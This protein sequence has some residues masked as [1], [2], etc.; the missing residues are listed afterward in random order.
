MLILGNIATAQIDINSPDCFNDKTCT[1]ECLKDKYCNDRFMTESRIEAGKLLYDSAIQKIQNNQ[2]LEGFNSLKTLADSDLNYW[3][4]TLAQYQI[5]NMYKSAQGV[6]KDI[7]L[8]I[9]YFELSIANGKNDP[10]FVNSP[11]LR[12]AYF[13]LSLLYAMDSK[14]K[15][16][17]LS[18]KNLFFAARKNCI[19]AQN[20]L[21]ND[22]LNGN[23]IKKNKKLSLALR[24]YE[25]N[26]ENNAE[27]WQFIERTYSIDAKKNLEIYAHDDIDKIIKSISKTEIEE[28]KKLSMNEDEL[29][30]LI[31]KTIVK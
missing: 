17:R 31:E 5:G 20:N 30:K 26:N 13:Q 24:F 10:I 15:N 29:F 25:I 8:S 21:A 7:G 23:G 18:N 19:F 14:Y 22:L 16:T 4:K 2:H 6:T 11:Y 1:K 27:S 3:I 28:A 12:S 9:K